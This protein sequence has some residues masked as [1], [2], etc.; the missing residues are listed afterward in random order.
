MQSKTQTLIKCDGAW[1]NELP[2]V[3]EFIK[4]ACAYYR[5]IVDFKKTGKT[6]TA[7]LDPLKLKN[8]LA[9]GCVEAY[10]DINKVSKDKDAFFLRTIDSNRDVNTIKIM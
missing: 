3:K 7:K 4:I 8:N 6:Y 1:I 2:K 9:T 5:G 10:F